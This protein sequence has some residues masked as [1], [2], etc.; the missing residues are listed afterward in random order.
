MCS[1]ST[2]YFKNVD[3]SLTTQT[4]QW[5]RNVVSVEQTFV[6]WDEKR[7]PSAKNAC[8]GGTEGAG[9][10]KKPKNSAYCRLDELICN[11]ECEDQLTTRRDLYGQ[12]VLQ[13][14]G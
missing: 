10:L 13:F 1:L 14:K 3:W 2:H 4:E 5:E 9:L 11:I 12:L 7:A 8:M 6:G